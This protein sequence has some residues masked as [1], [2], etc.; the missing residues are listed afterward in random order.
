MSETESDQEGFIEM[1]FEE[2]SAVEMLE[3]ANEY[4]DLMSN[5]RTTRH[6]SRKEVSRD[7]IELAIKTAGTAPSE[8]IF[9]HGHLLRYQ[10]SNSKVELGKP[11]RKRREILRGESTR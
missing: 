11:P 10:I 3:R 8:L 9:S 1:S 5:R 6:F 2:V 4:F 7:L